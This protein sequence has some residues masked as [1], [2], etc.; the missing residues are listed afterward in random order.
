MDDILSRLRDLMRDVTGGDDSDDDRRTSSI[1]RLA[2]AE[3]APVQDPSEE[4][5]IDALLAVMRDDDDRTGVPS[6]IVVSD[7]DDFDAIMDS[8]YFASSEDDAMRFAEALGD[9]GFRREASNIKDK[10]KGAKGGK[11]DKKARCYVPDG[12][13]KKDDGGYQVK[14]V[15]HEDLK[16]HVDATQPKK[17]PKRQRSD[18][19]QRDT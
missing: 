3:L 18:S 4:Q 16:Y 11:Y 9:V 6:D 1:V 19:I 15:E 13:G 8:I 7:P 2:A 10:L 5:M 14:D 12:K 17:G